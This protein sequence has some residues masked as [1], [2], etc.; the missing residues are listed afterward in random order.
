VSH[1][2][3]VVEKALPGMSSRLAVITKERLRLQWLTASRT[4]FS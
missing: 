3:L 1:G 4:V 2:V